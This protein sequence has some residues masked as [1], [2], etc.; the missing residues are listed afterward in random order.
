MSSNKVTIQQVVSPTI[1]YEI[2]NPTNQKTNETKLI[3]QFSKKQTYEGTSSTFDKERCSSQSNQH[4]INN[5]FSF[6][7][8]FDKVSDRN[9]GNDNMFSINKKEKDSFK[10]ITTNDYKG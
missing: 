8:N 7:Q 5:A 6:N 2:N 4:A 3:S 9:E 10:S 1:Y